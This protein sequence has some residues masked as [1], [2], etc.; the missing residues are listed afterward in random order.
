MYFFAEKRDRPPIC[1]LVE[2]GAL[3]FIDNGYLLHEA[4]MTRSSAVMETLLECGVPVNAKDSVGRSLVYLAVKAERLDVL[5]VLLKRKDLDVN[6]Q[7][8]RRGKSPFHVAVRRVHLPAIRLLMDDER[9]NINLA[10][11][12]EET[13]LHFAA[14]W[15]HEDVVQMLLV[16]ERLHVNCLD[17]CSYTPLHL[18]VDSGIVSMVQLM[19]EDERFNITFGESM[20]PKLLHIATRRGYED[21]AQVLLDDGRF[22]P[23]VPDEMSMSPD[24]QFIVEEANPG[25]KG[26]WTPLHRAVYMRNETIIELLLADKRVDINCRSRTGKTPLH[27]AVVGKHRGVLELLLDHKDVDA[28]TIDD[29]GMT[30]LELAAE[31][32]HETSFLRDGVWDLAR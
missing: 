27:L 5:C 30:P 15:G 1:W 28:H 22:D 6:A 20:G 16:E 23:N 8:H 25:A 12:Y 24:D 4:A 32:E 29:D 3:E 21:I 2:K 19:L 14:R 18:A 26:E 17:V 13:P 31:V 9:V 7:E 11:H 10:D